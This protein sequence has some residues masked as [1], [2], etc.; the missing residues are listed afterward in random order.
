[1]I[2]STNKKMKPGKRCIPASF[3]S[4]ILMVE[5]VV[6]NP[7]KF[8][9]TF[10]YKKRGTPQM[11]FLQRFIKW[12]QGD[13]SNPP[14]INV[15]SYIVMVLVM[16]CTQFSRIRLC[17]MWIKHTELIS[18]IVMKQYTQFFIFLYKF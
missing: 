1:M 8:T 11:A 15:Y 7:K 10:E 6:E 13:S 14:R 3:P 18:S 5:H 17:F 12:R 16:V 9:F 4:F 2:D